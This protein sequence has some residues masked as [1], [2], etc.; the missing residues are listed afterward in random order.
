[1]KWD[2]L[3]SSRPF[4][5]VFK[6]MRLRYGPSPTL[7]SELDVGKFL[8]LVAMIMVNR[9]VEVSFPFRVFINQD[10]VASLKLTFVEE[11][12]NEHTY[13]VF[14]SI[15][16]YKIR[17]SVSPCVCLFNYSQNINSS[18]VKLTE[19]CTKNISKVKAAI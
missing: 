14:Y 17:V 7:G 11:W 5:I 13:F 15:D 18:D 8:F 1:M 6:G 4:I 16:L 10:T 9:V 19:H 3:L 12:T 2:H